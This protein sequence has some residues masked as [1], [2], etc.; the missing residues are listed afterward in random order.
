MWSEGGLGAAARSAPIYPP[1]VDPAVKELSRHL[2]G[3]AATLAHVDP[4]SAERLEDLSASLGTPEGRASWSETDLR[5]A[6][7]TERLAHAFAVRKEGGYSSNII[8][9]ADKVRNVLVLV[10]IFLTWFALAEAS[11]AY[12]RYIASNPEAVSQPFLLLWENHFGGEASPFAPTFSAVALLDA[13]L[14]ACIIALTLFAHGRR[15]DRDD[16]ID[17]TALTFQADLD[18]LLAASSVALARDRASRP[19]TLAAGIERLADRFD[20]G[21]QELLTRLRVEHDRLEQL[22]AR[23]EREF[24]DFAVFASGMRAGAEETHKVLVELRA[25]SSGLQTALDDLTNEVGVSTD[26]GRSLL[27]AIQGLERLTVNDLQADQALTRQIANAADALADAADRAISGADSAAQAARVATEASRGIGEIAQGL[28][29][30]QARVDAAMAAE[31]ESVSRLAEALRSG[32]GGMQSSTRALQEIERSLGAIQD[33]FG[34]TAALTAEQARALGDLLEA[35]EQIAGQ[36]ADVARELGSISLATVQRQE[37]TAR[38]VAS[39]V[40]RLDA[41]TSAIGRTVDGSALGRGEG[42]W[43]DPAESWPR[44]R[45]P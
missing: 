16:K 33:G 14:L 34:H 22:A 44:R 19:A 26:Q 32:S 18:N 29:R 42:E 9:V 23:R 13:V 5:R 20:R 7:N 27:G 17:R 37:M 28:A 12:A 40:S 1:P 3:M 45:E 2:A 35:Q 24:G 6:F 31:S 36:L 43:R 8:N 11:R 41:L 21:A 25:L 10:P 30:S 39:L 15:D 38:D 4:A